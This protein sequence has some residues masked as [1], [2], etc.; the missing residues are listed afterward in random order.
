MVK[1]WHLVARTEDE[2]CSGNMLGAGGEERKT[3]DVGAMACLWGA[4]GAREGENEIPLCLGAA[5][6]GALCRQ[7]GE[8]TE[9]EVPGRS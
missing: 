9:D 7:G 2:S 1:E 4:R 3:L 5:M 8:F 6:A